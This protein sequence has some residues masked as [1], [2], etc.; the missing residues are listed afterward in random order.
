[1]TDTIKT[2]AAILVILAAFFYA[3]TNDHAD[4]I[5]EQRVYCDNVRDGVWPDYNGNA[6]DICVNPSI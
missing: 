3:G 1:M 4:A 5:L 6:A 2:A